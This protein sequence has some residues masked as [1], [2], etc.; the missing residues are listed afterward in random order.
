MFIF[1]V[2]LFNPTVVQARIAQASVSGGVALNGEEETL[3]T[4]GGG[5]WVIIY[6][7]ISLNTPAKV[8]AFEVWN[9]FLAAGT[10]EC[11]VPLLSLPTAPRPYLG[12]RPMRPSALYTDAEVFPT[13]MEYAEPLIIAETAGSASLR[14]TSLSFTIERGGEI[15]GGEK[16][17]IGERAYRIGANVSGNIWK[18]APP[19]REAVGAGDAINF[20]WPMV[21]CHSQPGEDF[22][23]ATRQGK[24]AG[25]ASITFLEV[26]N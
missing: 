15:E 11:L 25:E 8:R 2:Q 9:E 5:R 3:L 13:T 10:Q 1:P 24:F 22:S 19:L 23:P 7:G 20:D 21:K 17:S 6:G 14:A 26:P 4:D 16:F 12:R 18:V